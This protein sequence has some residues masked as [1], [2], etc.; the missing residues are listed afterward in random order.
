LWFVFDF[1]GNGEKE[2]RTFEASWPGIQSRLRDWSIFGFEMEFGPVEH[3]KVGGLTCSRTRISNRSLSDR[4]GERFRGRGFGYVILD[5]K[6]K[7]SAIFLIK[8]DSP[9]AEKAERLAEAAVLSWRKDGER[10]GRPIP[11]PKVP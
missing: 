2:G 10:V 4:Q 8:A 7:I 9:D 5:G 3:G 6:I 1:S 11:R